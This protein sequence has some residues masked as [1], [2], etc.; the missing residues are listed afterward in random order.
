MHRQAFL[1]LAEQKRAEALAVARAT[2]IPAQV[3]SGSR[4]A[5]PP[6]QQ[7]RRNSSGGGSKRALM[8]AAMLRVG[9]EEDETAARFR[10]ALTAVWHGLNTHAAVQG[11]FGVFSLVEE[12]AGA[13]WSLA[14]EG[15]PRCAVLL[16][17]RLAHHYIHD[18][19]GTPLQYASSVFELEMLVP[20][21]FTAGRGEM[22]LFTAA[23]ESGKAEENKRLR[24][25]IRKGI[26]DALLHITP[27]LPANKKRKTEE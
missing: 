8:G 20:S 25:H 2:A 18:R 12:E 26:S 11:H 10:A 27:P 5:P 4:G 6:K 13:L 15:T 23:S 14:N 16:H 3:L 9:G 22:L 24:A 7:Q 19:D 17:L 21:A 1:L